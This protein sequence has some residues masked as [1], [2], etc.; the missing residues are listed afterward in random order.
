MGKARDRLKLMVGRAAELALPA[1]GREIDEDRNAARAPALKRS[2]LYSRL[3]RA[4]SRSD[5]I[6]IEKALAAFWKGNSG[7]RFHDHYAEPRFNLFIEHHSK[8]ID[9]LAGLVERS[10]ARFTRLVEIGCGDGAVLAW[11]AERL[12]C[13]SEAIG[14]DINTAVIERISVAHPPGGRLSFANAEAR[15][16]LMAHPQAGTV[17]LANGGVLEYFSQDSLDAILQTLALFPPAAIVLVEPVSPDHDL[18]NHNG[19]FIFGRERSF[20]HNH[21]HRLQE[22]GF[23]VMFGEEMQISGTRW[24]LM[25]G[26]IK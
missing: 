7:D 1:L 6:A 8:V 20:S 11:C 5:V 17:M 21:R 24:M 19:S 26:F 9:A 23:D 18:Q 16:W 14:L 15:D 22:A 25:I 13:I 12:P 4:Q 10:G 2:I 3:R